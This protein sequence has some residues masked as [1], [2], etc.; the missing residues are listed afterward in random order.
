MDGAPVYLINN[1]TIS[2]AEVFANNGIIHGIDAVLAVPGTEYPPVSKPNALTQPTAPT[3]KA[4]T[5]PTATPPTAPTSD[6]I[7]HGSA[8]A[9]VMS[10]LGVFFMTCTEVANFNRLKIEAYPLKAVLAAFVLKMT[11]VSNYETADSLMAAISSDRGCVDVF[12]PTRRHQTP[13]SKP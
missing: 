8:A 1:A 5:P 9:S 11:S 12:R 13:Q 2:I 10:I 3:P 6:A 7:V 4:P